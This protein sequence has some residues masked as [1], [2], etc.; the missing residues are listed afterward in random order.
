MEYIGMQR[1]ARIESVNIMCLEKG[2]HNE[3][4]Q[5]EAKPLIVCCGFWDM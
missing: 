5:L 1:Q 4:S 3:G 2:G